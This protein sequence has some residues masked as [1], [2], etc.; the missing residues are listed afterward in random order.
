MLD[1]PMTIER[2][3]AYSIIFDEAAR[4]HRNEH[5]ASELRRLAE[6]CVKAALVVISE[7]PS[8]SHSDAEI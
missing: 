6:N 2:L 8:Q 1:R 4:L 3:Q 7:T 5:V